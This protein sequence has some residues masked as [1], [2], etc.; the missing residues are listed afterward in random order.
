[1][2]PTV[3]VGAVVGVMWGVFSQRQEPDDDNQQEGSTEQ[4]HEQ[5]PLPL[6]DNSAQH[7][8]RNSS[9]FSNYRLT[10]ALGGLACLAAAAAVSIIVAHRRRNGRKKQHRCGAQ[11]SSTPC[12][13]AIYCRSWTTVLHEGLAHPQTLSI[14]HAG[15]DED[16]DVTLLGSLV[17][18]QAV[19]H[20]T[21]LYP[22]ELCTIH[23]R[24][25]AGRQSMPCPSPPPDPSPLLSP[26]PP[27]HPTPSCQHTET[28]HVTRQACAY[29]MSGMQPVSKMLV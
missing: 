10:T 9:R 18:G 3:L 5:A 29:Q 25:A 27:P 21:R 20:M 1:M 22:R 28:T 8:P 15:E 13:D 26:S 17:P 7:Q 24:H 12:R 6:Q 16:F 11:D 4:Q 23:N 2:L 14:T 19:L